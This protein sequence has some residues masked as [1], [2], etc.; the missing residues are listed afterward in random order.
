MSSPNRKR[1]PHVAPSHVPSTGP[2]INN[3]SARGPV[4]GSG[5]S[6]T[7]TPQR[8]SPTSSPQKSLNQRPTSNSFL[9]SAARSIDRA[10]RK[11]KSGAG[12]VPPPPMS[13]PP[14]SGIPPPPEEE[15]LDFPV[16]GSRGKQTVVLGKK[17]DP[18]KQL[19]T[20][21]KEG[22]GGAKTLSPPRG[23]DKVSP[24]SEP[25]GGGLV[26]VSE[27]DLGSVPSA[28]SSTKK[29]RVGGRRGSLFPER[30]G[31]QAGDIDD[32]AGVGVPA[33]SPA[34][35]TT[36][37][38]SPIDFKGSALKQNRLP[39]MEVKA[40]PLPMGG[41]SMDGEEL[42]SV[43]GLSSED[44]GEGEGEGFVEVGEA[45]VTTEEEGGKTHILSLRVEDGPLGVTV[46]PVNGEAGENP[47]SSFV[48]GGLIVVKVKSS[49]SK[50][51][52]GI[53]GGGKQQQVLQAGDV[54]VSVNGSSI[55]GLDF[56]TAISELSGTHDR[57][58]SVARQSGLGMVELKQ[59]DF[60]LERVNTSM[61]MG[62]SGGAVSMAMKYEESKLIGTMKRHQEEVAWA[63]DKVHEVVGYVEGKVE[64]HERVGETIAQMRMDINNLQ[65]KV[66]R[67]ELLGNTTGLEA[68]EAG[69]GAADQTLSSGPESFS[70]ST[71]SKGEER[72]NLKKLSL[73]SNHPTYISSYLSKKYTSSY[74]RSR[75]TSSN[76]SDPL[77]PTYPSNFTYTSSNNFSTGQAIDGW[78][79][80]M[81]KTANLRKGKAAYG[82][83]D[84]GRS[85]LARHKES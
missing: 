85:Y 16:V 60:F 31:A 29:V 23:G 49:K 25:M 45:D 37:Q 2:L 17:K 6:N 74:F 22:M 7:S 71:S 76:P 36:G 4:I 14:L 80:A 18:I 40:S 10:Q 82:W 41:E 77:L 68:G 26:D 78:T 1:A 30:G 9:G 28:S 54:I 21:K 81:R 66:G 33:P 59:R 12:G 72:E 84:I 32:G 44:E 65:E 38:L 53:A 67:L 27:P 5:S 19:Q 69:A 70:K 55:V 24:K 50:K 48:S 58:L 56:D 39:P 43:Q 3:A 75:L 64:R 61:R 57:S 13:P 79:A 63:I 35:V 83:H 8:L 47:N 34:N 42:R 20:Q 51:S 52:G 15:G 46:L 11:V 62:A 73:T